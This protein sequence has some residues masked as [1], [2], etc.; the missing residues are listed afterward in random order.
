[1]EPTK[2]QIAQAKQVESELGPLLALIKNDLQEFS[3]GDKLRLM[4]G[5]KGITGLLIEQILALTKDPI[6]LLMV[7]ANLSDALESSI[8]LGL[9]NRIKQILPRL[10]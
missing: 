4:I 7:A 3:A 6:A 1:M 5:V 8:K 2:E 9:A 10:K